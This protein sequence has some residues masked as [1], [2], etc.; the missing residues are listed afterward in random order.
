MVRFLALGVQ[1]VL[2]RMIGFR[3]AH[4]WWTCLALTCHSV[5]PSQR[6][7]RTPAIQVVLFPSISTLP[8]TQLPNCRQDS[9]IP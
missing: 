8:R 3:G 2:S 9:R 4:R 6:S 5:A 7:S 1:L